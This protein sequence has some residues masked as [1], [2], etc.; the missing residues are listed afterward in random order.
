MEV[1]MNQ[2][3]IVVS[4]FVVI[5][6][7]FGGIIAY[8][9]VSKDRLHIAQGNNWQWGDDWNN[10]DPAQ[11]QPEIPRTPEQPPPPP[12]D[13]EKPEPPKRPEKPIKANNWDEAVTQA[14]R[15]GMPIYILFGADW[16]S[17]CKKMKSETI[18]SSQVQDVLKNYVYLEVNTDRNKDLAKKFGVRALPSNAISNVNGDNLKF[19]QGYASA[20][21]F[22]QWLNDPSLFEQPSCSH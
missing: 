11:E 20:S 1:S 14:G 4:M 21:E 19:K 17:W 7:V 5:L 22:A 16:C 12:Q 2:Q 18:P 6:L 3:Q 13:Q 15:Y 10:P 9:V 8:D